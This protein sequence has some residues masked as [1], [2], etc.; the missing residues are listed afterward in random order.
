MRFSNPVFPLTLQ[1]EPV[2]YLINYILHVCFLGNPSKIEHLFAN[3][4][5]N[6]ISL[7]GMITSLHHVTSQFSSSHGIHLEIEHNEIRA[8]SLR[9]TYNEGNG[10]VISSVDVTEDNEENPSDKRIL[11]LDECSI[12]SNDGN[13]LKISAFAAVRVRHCTISNN[14]LDGVSTDQTDGGSIR[15]ESSLFYENSRSAM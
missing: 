6:G 11:C 8:T 2:T 14:E 7:S 15:L 4:T 12:H 1:Y 5:V 3:D 10:I 9:A 13:G